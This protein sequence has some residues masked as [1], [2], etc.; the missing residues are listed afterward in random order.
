MQYPVWHGLKWI[1][2]AGF[3]IP[4][5]SLLFTTAVLF[6]SFSIYFF[7][8]KEGAP[9][10]KIAS[11]LTF[12]VLSGL[13]FSR[14]VH[15]FF[16]DWS[17]FQNHLIEIPQIWKGGL[18]SHGGTIGFIVGVVLYTRFWGNL[19]YWWVFDRMAIGIPIGGA[20]IRL[21]NFANSE[22]YGK[23]SDCSY[24]IIFANA[25]V[26]PR[27]PIQLMEAG[28]YFTLGLIF[29]ILYFSN[30]KTKQFGFYTG[31]LLIGMSSLRIILE[32]FKAS[33]IVYFGMNTGQLLSIP[34]LVLGLIVIFAAHK[35]YLN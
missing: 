5:Y 1:E 32:N 21:G 30:W 7:A 28:A 3:Q 19:W 31:A 26:L 25:G 12:T 16:Y 34:F 8:K 11:L 9:T 33:E 10:N 13:I 22:L 15:V 4:T 2:I 6:G 18:A 23:L 24:C 29:F 27:Y 35:K 14:L 17:Y 20:I